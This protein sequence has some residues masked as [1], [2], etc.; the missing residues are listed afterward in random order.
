MWKRVLLISLAG[1]L[2]SGTA[3]AQAP[4]I[5]GPNSLVYWEMPT[6]DPATAGAC[7]YTISQGAAA[8][9]PLVGAVTCVAAVAP[10]VNTSCTV[11]LLAQNLTIG[12]GSIRM[13]ATCSGVTSLPS[14]A[15]AYVDLVIPIPTN[16]KFK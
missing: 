15:Y 14:T 13:E 16:V 9:V 10:A 2:L 6:I 7:S 8:F 1:L 12:S 3:H 11:N 5:V 4:I